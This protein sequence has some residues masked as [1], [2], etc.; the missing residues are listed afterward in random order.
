V[1][2]ALF[3][4]EEENIRRSPNLKSDVDFRV[5]IGSDFELSGPQSLTAEEPAE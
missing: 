2:S 1:L 5:I 4:V 3:E